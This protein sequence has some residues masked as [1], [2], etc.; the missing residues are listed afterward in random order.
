MFLYL[1]VLIPLLGIMACVFDSDNEGVG[2]FLDH[3]GLPLNYKVETLTIEGIEPSSVKSYFDDYPYSANGRAVLGTSFDLNHDLFL[4]FAFRNENFFS[5]FSSDDSASG[6]L[7]FYLLKEFYTSESLTFD[8]S[9]PIKE[10]LTLS[11]SWVLST[12]SGNR[13]V[14]SIAG[15]TNSSWYSKLDSW[16]E[17][18]FDTVFSLN[19]V[20]YDSL[21]IFP[22]PKDLIQAMKKVGDACRLQLKIS[23]KET[24]N[25]YRLNG[26]ST[27]FRPVLLLKGSNN[28]YSSNSP[29]RMAAKS[30]YINEVSDSQVLHGGGLRE[31]LIVELPKE[32]IMTALSEF[33]GDEFPFTEGDSM[34][35]RQMVVLAEVKIPLQEGTSKNT[36]NKPI[37]MVVASMIDSLG[38]ESRK[39]EAYK[40]NSDLVKAEGHP[41]MIFNELDT[42]SLQVTY[43]LRDFINKASDKEDFRFMVRLG[44]PVLQPNDPAY[45]DYINT[46]GDSIYFFFS[47]FDY[48]YYDLAPSLEKPM[49]LKLWL[50]TKRGE[51]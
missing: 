34:D 12:G 22:I 47:H 6:Q 24:S 37:Q 41:N 50:A 17:A 3:E 38:E 15:I 48:V 9:L 20:S 43:G 21:V 16:E 39:M 2:S 35:V 23:A 14:D 11:Y 7:E 18:V 5:E 36:L 40:I 51:E 33:Y 44:Y 10:N 4:D 1:F 42:L 45:T 49:T 26:A 19:I 46:E 30:S 28:T 8:D 32:K 25:L 29:F 31:S 27:P 13:F